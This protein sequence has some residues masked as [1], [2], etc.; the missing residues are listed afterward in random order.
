MYVY[1]QLMVVIS[2]SGMA[3]M[4]GVGAGPSKIW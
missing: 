2:S 4:L 3:A 1:D